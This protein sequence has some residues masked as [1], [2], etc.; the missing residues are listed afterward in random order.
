MGNFI[1]AG[2]FIVFVLVVLLVMGLIIAKLYK[3]SSKSIAFVRTG[4][5]GSKVIKDGGALVLPILH[6][7]INVNM[8]TIKLEVTRQ[9]KDALITFDRMR[10]DVS[11]EFYVR[12]KQD[13]EAIE[14]AAQTL[15]NKT[16]NPQ[17]LKSLVEGKFVDALRSV[18]SSMSMKD[19]HEQR[20]DFVQKVQQAVESDLQKNGLELESV[21]LTKFDQTQREYFNPDNAFD[22]EG[23]TRLTQ[24]IEQRKKIRNDIERDNQLQIAQKNLETEREQLIVSQNLEAARY[25]STK[26]ISLQ[27]ATQEAEIAQFEANKTRES[28]T[29]RIEAER[30]T[31]QARLNKNRDLKAAEIEAERVVRQKTIERDR[32]VK[33]AEIEQ[34]KQLEL[35][36]QN[37]R[38][39]L[40]KKSEEE[41]AARASA[42]DA[43]A[44]QV[45][46]TQ[47]VTT[48]DEVAQ[49]KRRQ[50]VELINAEAIARKASIQTVVSAEAEAKAAE[51]RAE[52]VLTTARAEAE[53]EQVRATGV[54]AR[55]EAEAEGQTKLNQAANSQSP[56]VIEM[57]VKTKVLEALPAIIR[58]AAK[59]MEKI[60]SIK[61][62]DMQGGLGNVVNSHGTTEAEANPNQSLPDQV[63]NAALRHRTAAPLVDS[64]LH[65]V[66]LN[67]NDLP[68]SV[69]KL[70]ETGKPEH[71]DSK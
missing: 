56:A 30:L 31:E 65:S 8:N 57:L 44:K 52:A 34:Q 71:K 12:V 66:G 47:K 2:G 40:A 18:A 10:V 22:A 42:E 33:E 25:E 64:L 36:Y 32:A 51:K 21:S 60:D 50:E 24:E 11:A 29:S 3:R 1:F 16:M 37:K 63:V 7:T 67:S 59:P 38:I 45:E 20:V 26:Q 13:N 4:S 27:K 61:I 46:A 69:G 48:I 14:I 58:E 15:G 5:G 55:Y 39:I 62:V 68:S 53:A 43:R 17:E 49:A 54:K 41:A 35:A 70:L 19:L 6:E 23:L 28:E 9:D